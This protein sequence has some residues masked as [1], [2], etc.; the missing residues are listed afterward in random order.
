MISVGLSIFVVSM[1]QYSNN[2]CNSM[3]YI[4]N[5]SST[6]KAIKIV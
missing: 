1:Y 4:V 5:T 2:I 3:H 6:V